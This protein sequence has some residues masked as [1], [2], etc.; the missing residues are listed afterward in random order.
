MNLRLGAGVRA[1][2]SI[3][4]WVI[5]FE[6]KISLMAV[7]AYRE[8]VD[9]SRFVSTRWWIKWFPLRKREFTRRVIVFYSTKKWTVTVAALFCSFFFA[10][11][12]FFSEI[13]CKN[14][15]WLDGRRWRDRQ[16]RKCFFYVQ[17]KGHQHTSI[18]WTYATAAQAQRINHFA[19]AMECHFFAWK[20]THK[21]NDWL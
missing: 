7:H 5:T 19:L 1:A 4:N 20:I 13:N 17:K 3:Q 6:K 21:I 8:Y 11:I 2:C 16:I 9:E 15:D 10:W 14:C 12:Q 18:E